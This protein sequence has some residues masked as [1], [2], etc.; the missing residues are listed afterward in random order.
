LELRSGR[1]TKVEAQ[2][3]EDPVHE[4]AAVEAGDRTR[5]AEHVWGADRG[6]REID[7]A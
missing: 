6:L 1:T 4:A 5:A 3:T 2:L 7:D